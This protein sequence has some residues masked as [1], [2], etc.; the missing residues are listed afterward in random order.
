[1]ILE[2]VPPPSDEDDADSGTV[3]EKRVVRGPLAD[4]DEESGESGADVVMS[5]ERRIVKGPLADYDEES[6]DAKAFLDKLSVSRDPSREVDVEGD[7]DDIG[8]ERKN[9]DVLIEKEKERE[10]A[11]GD[12]RGGLGIPH[13]KGDTLKKLE[14]AKEELEE[15]ARHVELASEY[16]EVLDSFTSKKISSE[17]RDH[18]AKTGK[19]LDGTAL[20][21]HGK[22][23]HSDIAKELGSLHKAGGHRVTWGTLKIIGKVVDR[24]LNDVVE[25]AKDL[26]RSLVG[27]NVK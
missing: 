22:E 26:A 10:R 3:Y 27:E 18:I 5:S 21:M 14:A 7:G 17:E 25:A 9:L 23:I 20:K 8:K 15:D 2:L 6:G 11:L 4:Y 13:E 24:V 12:A 1:M 19:M 16:N